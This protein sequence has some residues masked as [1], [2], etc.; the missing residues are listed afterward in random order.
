MFNTKVTGLFLLLV[1]FG[2]GQAK[3]DIDYIN[4]GEDVKWDVV[5]A[6]PN[7]FKTD[8]P[9]T[10]QELSG[11]VSAHPFFDLSPYV[12]YP[13]RLV[14]F[15]PTT[16]EG[17][18][19]H[20]EFDTVSGKRYKTHLYCRQKDIWD[21][22]ENRIKL[23]PY[24]EG[25]IPRV[26]D[27]LG[28]PQKIRVFGRRYY[29][30]QDH[31][32]AAH[33][34]RVVG[35]IVE[36]Y[37]SEP[38]CVGTK[39]W[40][41]RLVLIAVDPNDPKFKDVKTIPQ[42]K[43]WVDWEYAIAFMSNQRGFGLKGEKSTPA[44]RMVGEIK[45]GFAIR[46][47]TAFSHVFTLQELKD[48]KRSCRKLYD[49]T[50][51]NLGIPNTKR[52][53]FD[54]KKRVTKVSVVDNFHI[55]FQKF[56]PKFGEQF[57]TCT[58]FVATSNINE[59]HHRHWF[60]AYLTGFFRMYRLGYIYNCSTGNWT[61]NPLKP[62]GDYKY[63]M[64]DLFRSCTRGRVHEAFDSAVAQYRSFQK[65]YQSHYRYIQ[66]DS[67]P[68]GTHEKLYSWVPSRIKRFDCIGDIEPYTDNFHGYHSFGDLYFNDSYVDYGDS[69]RAIFP[70]DVKWAFSKGK[71]RKF[72]RPGDS[73]LLE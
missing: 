69:A 28:Y 4:R 63:K 36:Q 39:R 15:Y 70:K 65:N 27:E 43:K 2:C 66:Y 21:R 16:P 68:G 18:P 46:F 58:D 48:I 40:E 42:L 22:Y 71:R 61:K 55:E 54:A 1:L 12:E 67:G 31:G 47:A 23:P 37:C 29:Y 5:T 41:S 62:N 13:D 64:A 9:Y 30:S 6:R 73:F 53:K 33:R 57:Q 17:S 19:V 3:Q 14:S 44:Y 59:D 50:W 49:Y 45:S 24:T 8:R 26:L 10:H 51:K 25:I 60:F 20:F 72:F 34:V 7:W 11:D 38:P 35:G 56:L 32:V 52:R